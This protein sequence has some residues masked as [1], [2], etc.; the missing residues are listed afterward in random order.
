MDHPRIEKIELTPAHVPFRQVVRDAMSASEGG[1]GMAIAAEEEWLGGDFVICKLR[2][3]DGSVGVGEAFVWLPETG[4]SPQ[5]VIDVI[6]LGRQCHPFEAVR[7]GNVEIGSS[8][9]SWEVAQ[10]SDRQGSGRTGRP[11]DSTRVGGAG[12]GARVVWRP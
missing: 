3:E 9:V 1:L 4:V 5:Q 6:L 7:R 11:L 10:T 8:E 2:A 12:R